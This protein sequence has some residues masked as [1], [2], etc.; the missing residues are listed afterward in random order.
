MKVK[1]EDISYK[2]ES[3]KERRVN[4]NLR[5]EKIEDEVKEVAPRN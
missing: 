4:R 5:L 2:S 1:V 3:L